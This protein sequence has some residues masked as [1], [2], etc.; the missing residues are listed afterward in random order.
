[1]SVS[2]LHVLQHVK[3]YV[4]R[5]GLRTR[6]HAHTHMHSGTYTPSFLRLKD[7]SQVHKAL[8]LISSIELSHAHIPE[9]AKENVSFIQVQCCRDVFLFLEMYTVYN[10]GDSIAFLK[11]HCSASFGQMNLQ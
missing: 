5:S 10:C 9:A 4:H 3:A 11:P 6:A 7:P 8:S 2:V 1:M